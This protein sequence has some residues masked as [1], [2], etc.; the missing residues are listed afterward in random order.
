MLIVVCC[1]CVSGCVLCV[2]ATFSY[3]TG[4]KSTSVKAKWQTFAGSYCKIGPQTPQ[5]YLDVQTRHYSKM[6][7]TFRLF[8][9]K[10]VWAIP[11]HSMS[12]QNKTC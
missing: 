11:G 7:Q 8:A 5:I 2:G 3:H 10:A 9:C 6:L 4:R 1:V 12:L